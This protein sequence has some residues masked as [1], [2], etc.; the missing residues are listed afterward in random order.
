MA[1]T[2][3]ITPAQI[4]AGRALLDWSQEQLAEAAG[5]GLSSVRDFEKERRGSEVGAVRAIRQAL[6][7]HNVLLLPGEGDNGPGVR[8]LARTP[9]VLRRPTK[10]GRWDALTIPV[11]WRGR[12]FEIFLSQDL[13]DDLGR[14]RE[15]RPAAEY[16]ALFDAHR[17]A[18]LKSA[19]AAIDAGRVAPD[20]RVHLTHDDFPEF[21]RR[22]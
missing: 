1:D 21:Q 16:V 18:I 7:N 11:E 10:L 3:P 17:A 22:G 14:F 20:R 19:A 4:R 2:A 15:T 9:N 12:E 5:V 13:L 8:L 6:E